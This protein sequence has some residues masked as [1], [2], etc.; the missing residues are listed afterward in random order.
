[1]DYL[2]HLLKYL[3]TDTQASETSG[4]HPSSEKEKDLSR[5]LV[6][7]LHEMGVSNAYMDEYGIVYAHIDG[8]KGYPTIGL[9]SHVDTAT[10]VSDTDVKPQIIKNYDGGTIILNEE[11]KMDTTSFPVLKDHIGHDLVVT[12]GDTLL[13]A[14]DKAGIT[15]IMSVVS[16]LMEDPAIK[17]HPLSICFTVDEEIGEGPLNFS[18]EKMNADYAYSCDGSYI[19]DI[20]IKNFNA[21]GVMINIR[22]NAIHPGE[23]KG[24]LVNASMLLHEILSYLDVD[25]TPLN[26]EGEEGFYHL[27]G[28][29]GNS[30]ECH[31]AMIIRD[32]DME[33]AKARIDRIHYAQKE[34]EKK[35]TGLPFSIE[36]KEMLQYENM[37]NYLD[38]NCECI[39]KAEAAIIKNGLTPTYL[40]I[41]GGTDGATF[42]KMGLLTPNLGTGSYNY[43]SRYEFIDLNE[44]E[45]MINILTDI[46]KI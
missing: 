16:R 1:M 9:N 24:K 19:N 6:E 5:I 25:D 14:D 30:E 22:G 39:K 43:H 13:G 10:E 3:K 29:Q 21:Y 41:R 44:L 46:V 38:P 8:E 40:P 15:V 31:A 35:Y 27:L 4:L 32:F 11:Y 2:P 7:E 23:G 45:K 33:K 34:V 42:T 37:Y 20:G 18:L 28:V 12:S 26:S 36:I 17:H